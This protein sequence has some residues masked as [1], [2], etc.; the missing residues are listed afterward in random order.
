VE[1]VVPIHN[2]RPNDKVWTPPCLIVMDSETSVVLSGDPE[3]LGLRL[4]VASRF[5]RRQVRKRQGPVRSEM[6]RTAAGLAVAVADL[7][8]GRRTVWLYAHNLA[9][10]LTTT[11]LPEELLLIGWTVSEFALNSKSPW[12]RM[13][14]GKTTLTLCD[15]WSWLPQS[16]NSLAATWGQRKLE[17]PADADP[18]EVWF[19][20]CADD[21]RLTARA[22]LELMAWWDAE[23]LGRW[24]ITGPACGWNAMRH[25]LS[26]G[27]VTVDPDAA[28][29]ASDRAAIRGG[30]R[31]VTRIGE[32]ADGP[33]VQL[34]FHQAYATIAAQL[35]LPSKRCV[36]FAG[37]PVEH[38]YLDH[39]RLGVIAEVTVETEIPRYPMKA[40]GVTFYPV[41]TFKTTLAGPEIRWARSNGDLREVHHGF[42]HK[43]NLGLA[44]WARWILDTSAGGDGTVPG[45]AR[46][47]AKAW[48]RSVIGKFAAR[49][50]D[51]ELMG[52]SH[53]SGW[54]W[55]PGY[56][57]ARLCRMST[58]EFCQQR[59]RISHDLE[60]DNSYPGVLAWVESEC[61]WRL[62]AA[63]ERL[64]EGT[65][66]QADTDG[67]IV[68]VG[69][70]RQ[71]WG[72]IAWDG[73]GYGDPMGYAA[74][75]CRIL[76]RGL[77]PLVLRPKGMFDQITVIGPQHLRLD[78]ETRMSGIRKDATSDG[79]GGLVARV[80]PGLAWQMEN[81]STTGYSR[82][83]RTWTVPAVTAHRWIT[84]DGDALPVQV[85]LDSDGAN[86]LLPW[87]ETAWCH[88]GQVVGPVQ[89]SSLANLN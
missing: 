5:D 23:E 86:R 6:G 61:R 82:P 56:D 52:P 46:I 3:V 51:F 84:A 65:W 48:G 21:V 89:H 10:D 41:G 53:G 73:M 87:S 36:A 15:S 54:R 13:T 85:E 62:S 39:P 63:L 58:V 35:P 80:W 70:L 71:A 8:R 76:N 14:D 18:D 83:L 11:R 20:R 30:R 57:H 17:L 50:S 49:S 37:L 32:F 74:G 55:E 79:S 44:R 34:D 24:T 64:P 77:E 67:V 29:I 42:I 22:I 75:I 7:C 9:F 59:W 40:H 38:R 1:R 68:D 26:S 47:A 45:V 78:D 31:D 28:G 2:L 12:L 69:A 72:P 43:L 88:A 19:A 66:L 27:L 81:G 60:G 25:K 16:L 33:Y 4:W